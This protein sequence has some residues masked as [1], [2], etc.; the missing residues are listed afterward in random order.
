MGR[1]RRRRDPNNPVTF[2]RGTEPYSD[3]AVDPG[4]AA[5]TEQIENASRTPGDGVP[6]GHFASRNPQSAIRNSQSPG[7][8]APQF[9]IP[10][11]AF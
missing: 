6:R 10:R 8:R 4:V 11:S 5:T 9:T 7:L 2:T 1:E 3:R